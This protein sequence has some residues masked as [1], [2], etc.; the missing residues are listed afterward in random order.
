LT[1]VKRCDIEREKKEN[2]G[3][4]I[5][6]SLSSRNTIECQKDERG[7]KQEKDLGFLNSIQRKN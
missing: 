2:E 6:T 1:A 5:A 3:K 4:F 7:K